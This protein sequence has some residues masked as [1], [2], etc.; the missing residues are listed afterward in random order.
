MVGQCA[1][2]S[3]TAIFHKKEMPVPFG[4]ASREYGKL[5]RE[6]D[7]DETKK[8][9]AMQRASETVV[10][11]LEMPSATELIDK[12]VKV[13]LTDTFEDSDGVLTWFVG[14]VNSARDDEDGVVAEIEWDGEWEN[15]DDKVTP[16]MLLT[17]DGWNG[18]HVVNN[19][20]KLA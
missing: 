17:S 3:A 5:R 8:M 19:S 13:L 14:K 7:S 16:D 15:A 1:Q 9:E 2:S 20:W 12:R 10:Q 6:L 18:K 11:P 4:T